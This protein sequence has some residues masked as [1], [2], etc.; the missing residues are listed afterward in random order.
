MVFVAFWGAFTG[1]L[2]ACGRGWRGGGACSA[3]RCLSR[4]GKCETSG[5]WRGAQP[6]DKRKRH[7]KKRGGTASHLQ[8][9]GRLGLLGRIVRHGSCPRR[10]AQRTTSP[11]FR[12]V[13]TGR[14]RV[15]GGLRTALRSGSVSHL[16]PWFC[17][18]SVSMMTPTSSKQIPHICS[19]V[20]SLIRG[21]GCAWRQANRCASAVSH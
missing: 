16:R 2:G 6:K 9:P 4:R 19:D 5:A 1:S 15:G 21:T 8:R 7:K 10:A 14:H 17:L 12:T 11:C 13:C 20:P 3:R 18:G